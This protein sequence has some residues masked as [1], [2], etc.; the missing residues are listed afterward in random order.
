MTPPLPRRGGRRDRRAIVLT[1][2]A[3][4]VL[5]GG[6]L[7]ASQADDDRRAEAGVRLFRALLAAD[8]DL[9]SKAGDDGKLLLVVF[10]TGDKDRAT[11]LVTALAGDP[12][13][14]PDPIRDLPV[15]LDTSVDPTFAVYEGKPPAGIFFAQAPPPRT[16]ATIVRYGIDHHVVVYSPFEGHVEQGV[17]GGLSVEAQV[18]PYVNRATLE[19]SHITLKA[20]FMKVAKVYG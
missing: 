14:G 2:C 8:V 11:T 12:K 16:I 7:F 10:H 6:A 15:R 5:L 13:D 17:L 1:A 9:A 19:A 4:A 18:R 3:L 20:F